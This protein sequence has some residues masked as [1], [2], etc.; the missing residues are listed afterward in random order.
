MV[1]EMQ[2]KIFQ[3]PIFLVFLTSF[4]LSLAWYCP[5]G[6]LALLGAFLPLW[7]L[8]DSFEK[9]AKLKIWAYVYLSLFLWNLATTWWVWNASAGG[10]VAMLVAN[11][12]LMSLPWLFYLFSRKKL[13]NNLAK[14]AFIAAWLSFEYGHLNWELSW[15]WLN[16]GNGFAYTHTLVQWYEYTGVLGGTLWILLSNVLLY[17]IISTKKRK[18]IS[19]ALTVFFLPII[20]SFWIYF[21]Y[22]EKGEN[23]EIVVVQPNI[24][25][26]T[27]KF[28]GTESFI[29]YDKQAKLF[30]ELASQKI[31]DKTRLLLFPETAFDEGYEEKNIHNYTPIRIIKEYLQKY[32]QI[33]LLGGTTSWEIYGEHKKT[34]TARR[35]LQIGYYDVFNTAMF[36][37][38]QTDTVAFY[39]KSKLVPIVESMPFPNIIE[40]L[41][42]SVIIDLGGTSGGLG[43]QQEREVF[44][45]EKLGFA[46]IIC[47]ES[48]YGEYVTEYVQKG[49]N[50]LCIITNDGW[51]G[52]TPGYR[53]HWQMARLRAIETRRA[54]ARSAN[55][56]ISGFLDQ[57]GNVIEKTPYWVKDVRRQSLKSNTEQTFY[58]CFGDYLGK[59]AFLGLLIFIFLLLLKKPK[60][61]NP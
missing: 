32:P 12:L 38:A 46:P 21:D 47:Y 24:D 6:S 28:I 3:K 34:Y 57:K 27:E 25:P 26:Y 51:W 44:F 33:S 11:T 29:P 9:V 58:V 43:W 37:E 20:A 61:E 50:I 23:V 35:N 15:S 39:H 16:L 52:D 59:F 17:E 5:F 8:I 19:V 41:L 53:Q 31:T 55:T 56:G 45:K 30:L 18:S 60:S 48:I 14:Y 36:L 40:K 1:I 10:A 13:G 54:V 22:E 49:A 2:T 4:L 7:Y 42:G